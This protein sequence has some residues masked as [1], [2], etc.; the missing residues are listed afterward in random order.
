M[1]VD[2][3]KN[4]DIMRFEVLICF[5]V[6]FFSC[7]NRNNAI[8][9]KDVDEFILKYRDVRF[10]DLKDISIAQRG[11]NVGSEVYVVGNGEG[12]FPVYFV[13]F[14]FQKKEITTID[15][16]NLEKSKV[17]DYL[18]KDKISKAINVIKKYNLYFFAVDSSQ[19]V[20]IN[21]FYANEPAYFLRL[22]AFT[23]DST[24]KR[25]YVYELYKDRWYLNKTRRRN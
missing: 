14:D 3:L 7:Y 22:K 10:D 8:T 4:P 11:R 25:G 6:V 19:N 18:T 2:N 9:N 24:I 16:T 21:P 12:S 17:Q 15:K 20:Y 1:G 13:T 5:S 23:G